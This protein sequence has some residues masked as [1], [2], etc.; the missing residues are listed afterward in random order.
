VCL[1][2]LNNFMGNDLRRWMHCRATTTGRLRVQRSNDV[3]PA[4]GWLQPFRRLIGMAWRM[5]AWTAPTGLQAVL[6]KT[7]LAHGTL[8]F[9]E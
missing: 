6:W 9:G 1:N 8:N 7:M 4:G 3:A 2:K 5:T